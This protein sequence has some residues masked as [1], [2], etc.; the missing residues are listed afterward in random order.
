MKQNKLP[1]LGSKTYQNPIQ[2]EYAAS[3]LSEIEAYSNADPFVLKFAGR[4]YCYSTGAEGVHVLQSNDLTSFTHLGYALKEQGAYSYW[5]PCVFYDNGLFYMYYSSNPEGEK[6]DHYHF[7][8]IAVSETPE[9]PFE[10]KK[11]LSTLF[12]IDPH[13]VRDCDGTLYLFYSINCFTATDAQ[14]AGTSIV[15]DRML[16]P[17]TPEGNPIPVILPSLEEE[18][19][20]HNRFNDGR[21]WYTVEGAFYLEKHGNAY[22]MYSGNAFQSPNYFTGYSVAKKNK[23]IDQLSWQKYPDGERFRPLISMN[24]IV[25]GTG[26]NSVVKAPN[27]VDDW[28][29]YHGRSVDLS[30]DDPWYHNRVMRIDPLFF[31][32]ETLLTPAPTSDHQDAPYSPAFRTLFEND[33]DGLTVHS[34]E[35]SVDSGVVIQSQ[36]NAFASMTVTDLKLVNHCSESWLSYQPHHMGGRYG[37]YGCYYDNSKFSASFLPAEQ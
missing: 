17:L 28:I 8:K 34:G 20:Q 36:R 6:D 12:A 10:Y 13:V 7:L 27:N 15:A 23:N 26:H 30:E 9:G 18:I 4:Y 5:A 31:G 14:F 2:I 3:G 29:I 1:V 22:V 19:F 11:S 33:L 16:D 21:D 35:W 25:M 37:M 24:K 32:N